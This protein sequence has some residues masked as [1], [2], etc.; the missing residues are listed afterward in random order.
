MSNQT[1]LKAKAAKADPFATGKSIGYLVRKTHRSFTRSLEKRLKEHGISISMWFFLRLLWEEEGLSQKQFSEQLNL[2][3]PTTVS[4]MDN[5]EK[6]GLIRRVRN[7]T[8]RRLTNI[9]LTDAG[10][11]LQGDIIHVAGEVNSIATNAV[12]PW[13]VEA[14]RDMLTRLN[15]ALELDVSQG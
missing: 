15:A 14:L 12:S 4:A 8:D 1:N 10:R 2:T 6:R 5:L 7:E 13:E 3:Q 11:A 9:F